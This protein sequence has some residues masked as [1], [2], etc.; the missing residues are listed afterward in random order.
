MF[1]HT[2]QYFKNKNA[3]NI[4]CAHIG[5]SGFRDNLYDMWSS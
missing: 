2:Q 5:L 4:V 3:N 1:V